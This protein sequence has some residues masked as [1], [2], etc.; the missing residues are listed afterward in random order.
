LWQQLL[1]SLD[2]RGVGRIDTK[3]YPVNDGDHEPAKVKESFK[4]SVEAL[5]RN[6]IRVFYLHKPDR[7]VPFER[8]LEAVNEIYKAGGL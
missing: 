3:V 5:G 8:T 7:T 4:T 6:K 2:M 1:A